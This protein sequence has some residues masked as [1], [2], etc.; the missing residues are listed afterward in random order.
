MVWRLSQTKYKLVILGSRT[1]IQD[2][3]LNSAMLMSWHN[4]V[5]S[6]YIIDECYNIVKVNFI[7]EQ[8]TKTQRWSRCSLYLFP[9]FNFGAR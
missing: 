8:A 1:N 7:L 2:P 5:F 3:F 6:F 9:F 4:V